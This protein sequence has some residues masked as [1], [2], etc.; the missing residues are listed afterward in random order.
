MAKSATYM[1]TFVLI[2]CIVFVVC[3]MQAQAIGCDSCGRECASACGTRHFRTCCFNYLRKRSNI[4]PLP[5]QQQQ[6]QQDI[7][8]SGI[9]FEIWLAKSQLARNY[10]NSLSGASQDWSHIAFD[11]SA[12]W[13]EVIHEVKDHKMNNLNN[14]EQEGPLQFVFDTSS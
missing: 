8:P 5:A 1:K 14:N 2:S 7:P 9:N 6:Q 3:S 11:P 4:P 13:K 12:R 10:L